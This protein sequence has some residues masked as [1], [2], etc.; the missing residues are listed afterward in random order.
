MAT[1]RDCSA[2]AL[3]A[4]GSA[5]ASVAS[6]PGGVSGGVMCWMRRVVL[7]AVLSAEPGSPSGGVKSSGGVKVEVASSAVTSTKGR[8]SVPILVNSS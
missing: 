3:T 8:G 6:S 2:K 7:S 5:V 1:C 4:A